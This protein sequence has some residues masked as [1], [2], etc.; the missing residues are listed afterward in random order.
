MLADDLC[1]TDDDGVLAQMVK[2]FRQSRCSI[3]A[4][5]E[6]SDDHIHQYGVVAGELVKD[7]I[8]RVTDM[9]EKPT[10]EDQLHRT[11]VLLAAI[12]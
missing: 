8:Y 11:W 2:L 6:V 4:V 5:E 1:I 12:Y 3:V 9:V 10:K 7:G